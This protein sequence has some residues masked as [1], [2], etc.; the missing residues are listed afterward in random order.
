MY[1]SSNRRALFWLAQQCNLICIFRTAHHAVSGSGQSATPV[2]TGVSCRHCSS[3]LARA[4]CRPSPCGRLS[5]TSEYYD[6]S[7]PSAPV[8]GRC[9]Y[10]PPRSSPTAT[11]ISDRVRT[12]NQP[13]STGLELVTVQ[14]ASTPVPL[15]YLP[16]SL[17]RPGPSGSTRPT[18]LCRGCSHPPHQPVDQAAANF[19]TLLR[20][21]SG[22]GLSPPL[23]QSAP[24]GAP[25]L[26]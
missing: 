19:T 9:A 6:D 2:F 7:V 14:E 11:T 5:E 13:R 22:E 25:H 21:D 26:P 17:T 3:L 8:S 1:R 23:G 18:R 4:H 20:Q 16:V 15:V 12:A 24:R 10:P